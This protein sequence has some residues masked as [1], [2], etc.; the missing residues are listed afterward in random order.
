LKEVYDP[1][2]V[3]FLIFFFYIFVYNKLTILAFSFLAFS[4]S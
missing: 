3:N 2:V 1:C 4:V